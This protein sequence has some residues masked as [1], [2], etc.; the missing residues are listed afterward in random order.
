MC[1]FIL[2]RDKLWWFIMA[3]YSKLFILSSKLLYI[4]QIQTLAVFMKFLVNTK[5]YFFYCA[6]RY[7]RSRDFIQ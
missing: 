1:L 4:V 5:S 3:P 7:D 6:R 2:F